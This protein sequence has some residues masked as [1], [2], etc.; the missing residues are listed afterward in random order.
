MRTWERLRKTKKF[1]HDELCVGRQMKCPVPA[2][3]Q[4]GKY[5]PD[6]KN[7]TMA[8]P[9][10]FLAWQPLKPNEP[11]KADPSD[12]FSVCPAITIMPAPSYA[13]YVQEH[14]FDRYQNIHR[15]QEMGQ[16]LTMQILFSVYEPGVRLPGFAD[17]LENGHPD[18]SLMLDGTEAGL[19]TLVNW[20]DDA[21]ELL[22]RERTIPGTDLILEDDNMMYSLFTDQAYIVDRRPIYYG[23]LNVELKGY[24]NKGSDHGKPTRADRLL[25]GID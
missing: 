22:L 9:R 19:E 17:G 6:I 4:N 8:E 12:P 23:F 14:R 13:R 16:S 15:S 3:G 5:G 25:D 7:F 18:M 10:V 1:F 21:I 11:G 20:M 24:A 2:T